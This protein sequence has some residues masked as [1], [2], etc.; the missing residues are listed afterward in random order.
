LQRLPPQATIAMTSHGADEAV[1]RTLVQG[2]RQVLLKPVLPRQLVDAV[3]AALGYAPSQPLREA[4][5]FA[6]ALQGL[7]SVRGARVLLVDDND[8]NR[9]LGTE[10]LQGIGIEVDTADDGQQAVQKVQQARYDLVL[11]DMQMPVMDGVRA[12]EHIRSLTAFKDLPILAMT[13]NAMQS[14]KDRCLRA[15]MNGHI[16]KPIEPE[17]L[18]AA[19]LRWIAPKAGADAQESG[20][21]AGATGMPSLATI[22]RLHALPQLDVAQGLQRVINNHA[23][24][25]SLLSKFVNGQAQSVAQI[26]Q[27]CAT[28]QTQEALRVLHTLKG[29]AATIGATALAEQAAKAEKMLEAGA[30]SAL[31]DAQWEQ[32]QSGL[33]TLI[34]PLQSIVAAAPQTQATG[35]QLDA[36]SLRAKL[37]ALRTL[38]LENDPGATD[39]LQN[40]HADLRVSLP[41]ATLDALVAAVD[42]FDFDA[43]LTVLEPYLAR[44]G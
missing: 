25:V 17:L 26:R 20:P 8:L 41:A 5:E 15:G 32:L 23:L 11:M 6:P 39:W 34:A 36:P 18:F 7:A 4:H 29:T 27:L 33:D 14:D 9:Q 37:L 38:V 21:L 44:P 28:Q 13:A 1:Q 2:S 40:A 30:E 3:W 19:M 35:L 42:G 10:L 22:D 43:A 24:Y 31:L 12:T 16:A